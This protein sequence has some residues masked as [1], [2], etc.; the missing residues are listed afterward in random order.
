MSSAADRS[1]SRYASVVLPVPAG[2]H[3]MI[4]GRF[5]ADEQPRSAL[6]RARPG[7]AARRTPRRCGDASAPRAA[8]RSRPPR[9]SPERRMCVGRTRQR[10]RTCPATGS[11][12]IRRRPA[13]ARR[14]ARSAPGPTSRCSTVPSTEHQRYASPTCCTRDRDPRVALDVAVLPA[15][16]RGVDQ[17]VAVSFAPIQVNVA[18]GDPSAV[19]GHDPGEVGRAEQRAILLGELL[20]HD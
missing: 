1:A 14:C 12:P 7:A 6:A 13:P 10:T 4:D 20:V 19:Q 8:G 16:H 2:P 17:H 11:S 9:Y 18:C 3:R 15:A 5:A